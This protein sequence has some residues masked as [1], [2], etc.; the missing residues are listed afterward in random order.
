MKNSRLIICTVFLALVQFCADH[1]EASEDFPGERNGLIQ[2]RDS[3]TSS[4]F[5]LHSNWTGPPCHKNLSR[6]SGISCFNWH[7]VHI[8]LENGSLT[9]SLPPLVLENIT[10]LNKLSFKN[11]SFYG[12]LPNLRNLFHLQVVSLSHNDFSGAIPLEYIGLP[13][14]EKLELQDNYLHGSIPPFNQGTLKD[15]NVSHNQLLGEIP[16]TPALLKFSKDSFDYNVGLCGLPVSVPCPGSA[17]PPQRS[18]VSP[19]PSPVPVLRRRRKKF[20]F[21]TWV[22]VL[23]SA[24]AVVVIISMLAIVLRCCRRKIGKSG[25]TDKRSHWSSESTEGAERNG[26]LVFSSDNKGMFDLDELLRASAEIIG[27]GKLGITY[28]AVM[29]SGP[30]TVK[31]LKMIDAPGRK[32]F[33]QHLS[34]LGKMK[35]ENIAEII[36]YFHS[37]EEKLIIYEYVPDGTLSLMEI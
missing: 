16:E 35:H 34:V 19:A 3:I 20:I 32:E 26:G 13:R 21:H 18:T 7:V 22:I 14:L 15:F 4:F 25:G 17:P 27:R 28:K 2:L 12:P 33:N 5:N 23:I 24:G 6:W 1:V 37:D 31:R 30:V 29:E 9:G 10:F 36:S 11:N 8:S